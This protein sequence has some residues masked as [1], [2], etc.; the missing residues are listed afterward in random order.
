MTD[1][2]NKTL[3]VELSIA[4]DIEVPDDS[5]ESWEYARELAVELA[6]SET[7]TSWHIAEVSIIG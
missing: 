2:T 1:R 6:Q 3:R 7:I 4:Y 5:D